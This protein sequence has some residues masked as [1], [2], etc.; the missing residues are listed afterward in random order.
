MANPP[1]KMAIAITPAIQSNQAK[2]SI[3][4]LGTQFFNN[5][6]FAFFRSNLLA[7]SQDGAFIND[8]Y[9]FLCVISQLHRSQVTATKVYTL[10]HLFT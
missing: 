6:I 5:L 10:L 4:L 1:I 7:P 8:F 2:F 3:N 9:K